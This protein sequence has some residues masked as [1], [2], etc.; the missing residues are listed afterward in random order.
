MDFEYFPLPTDDAGQFQPFAPTVEWGR[1]HRQGDGLSRTEDSSSGGSAGGGIG[2]G[3]ISATASGGGFSGDERVRVS[4]LDLTGDTLPE[5]I[6]HKTNTSFNDL[7]VAFDPGTGLQPHLRTGVFEGANL[8]TDALGHTDRTG[9]MVEG[10]LSAFGFGGGVSYTRSTTEDD[11]IVADVNGDGFPDLASVRNNLLYVQLNDGRSRFGAATAWGALALDQSPSGFGSDPAVDAR[12]HPVD[13]LVRFSA[14]FA[15]QVTVRGTID[16]LEP[17]G[18]GVLAEIFHNGTRIWQRTI[19]G[20]DIN[21]CAVGAGDSCDGSGLSV[22]LS[23]GDR[24]FTKLNSRGSAS[25]DQVEFNTSI[26]YDVASDLRELREPYG[27]FIYRFDHAADHRLAGRPKLPWVASTGKRVHITGGVLKNTTSDDVRILITKK[28]NLGF[29]TTIKDETLPATTAGLSIDESVE[30]FTGESLAFEMLSDSPIDPDRVFWQPVVT[31]TEYCRVDATTDPPSAPRCGEVTCTPGDDG[32]IGCNIANDP[33]PDIPIPFGVI[34]QPAQ[35]FVPT[36]Q[37]LPAAATQTYR[38][39]AGGSRGLTLL[40]SKLATP[41]P[42]TLLIQGVHRKFEKRILGAGEVGLFAISATADLAANDQVFFSV[43][44]EDNPGAAVQAVGLV[45]GVAQP[46]N[47]R[48]IDPFFSEAFPFTTDPIDPLSGGYHRWFPDFTMAALEFDVSANLLSATGQR[49]RVLEHPVTPRPSAGPVPLWLS[50]DPMRSS[51]DLRRGPRRSAAGAARSAA[52]T[53]CRSSRAPSG[54][55]PTTSSSRSTRP[56]AGLAL[57]D[58]RRRPNLD[59]HGHERRSLSR[60]RRQRRHRLQR[61]LQRIRPK[62]PAM[63][64]GNMRRIEHRSA[65]AQRQRRQEPHQHD[66]LHRQEKSL[67]ATGST[68]ASTMASRPRTKT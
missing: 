36:F 52:S 18:N 27:A 48:H 1:A 63:P 7:R 5:L 20:E 26:D 53:V 60:Q 15:G 17:G 29:L 2:I 61:R 49:Q 14:P 44:T 4:F 11:K 43:L 35:V 45:D 37:F 68:S 47:I 9:W 12:F 40:V 3:P 21:V 6:D 28:D 23:A 57:N 66:G 65:R 62:Q 50:G 30:V 31:Y 22:A 33:T 58:G 67:L 56:F 39:T 34:Q 19:E 16:K 46:V 51:A 41:S 8:V 54:T 38:E 24:I 10:G 13:P 64:G 42:L 32:Q 25:F 59:L 55:R